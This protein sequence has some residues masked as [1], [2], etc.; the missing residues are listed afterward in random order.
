MRPQGTPD[1]LE[2]RR[3]WA[4][5]LLDKGFSI[6]EVAEITE[7][8][9]SSV[10]RWWRAV[11]EGGS[12]ALATKSSSGRPTKLS[13]EQRQQLAAIVRT[14][15]RKAGFS[16]D[17]WTC[18]RVAHVI[19]DRFGVEYHRDHV[20]RIL[21]SLGFSQQKPQRR[22]RERDEEAIEKW[23]AEDWPR[24]KRGDADAAQPSYFL[25]KQASCSSP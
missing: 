24:I 22:A 6:G 13:E 9:V 5:E 8:H 17:L 10:K 25:T 7:V 3:R 15:A 19:R 14:G 4:V 16:T 18:R 12:D 23:R 21:H 20:G 11:A 2:A 1:R